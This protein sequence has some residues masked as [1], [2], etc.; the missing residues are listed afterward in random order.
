M[1]S[2]VEEIKEA[3]QRVLELTSAYEQAE[4]QG[5][6]DRI[7]RELKELAK[8]QLRVSVA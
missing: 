8:D 3:L 6:R 5:E 7:V 1:E 2:S 4:T